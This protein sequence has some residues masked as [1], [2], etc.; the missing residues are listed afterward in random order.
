MATVGGGE[1]LAARI[2]RFSTRVGGSTIAGSEDHLVNHPGGRAG[3]ARV[4]AAAG[5]PRA[6]FTVSAAG[7]S[8]VG[9]SE[10]GRRGAPRQ[11]W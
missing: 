5:A 10:G 4:G 6:V 7:H 8:Q 1:G 3:Y 2:G 9:L 11:A